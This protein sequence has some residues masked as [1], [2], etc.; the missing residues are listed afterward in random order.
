MG[1]AKASFAGTISNLTNGFLGSNYQDIFSFFVLIMV[2]VFRPSG[3]FGEKQAD[4]A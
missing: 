4:R 2:L 3:L 1:I